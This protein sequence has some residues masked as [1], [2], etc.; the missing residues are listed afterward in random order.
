MYILFQLNQNDSAVKKMFSTEL[1]NNTDKIFFF[2]LM[3]QNHRQFYLLMT[4]VLKDY[5][6]KKKEIKIILAHVQKKTKVALM[7]NSFYVV[8]QNCYLYN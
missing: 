8:I 2:L 5:Q 7:S 6:I 1:I 3:K 4:Y